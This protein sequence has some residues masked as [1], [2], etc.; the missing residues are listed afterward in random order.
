MAEPRTIY[1][2]T[3]GDYSDYR[4]CGVY[5][6]PAKAKRGQVLHSGRYGHN[7]AIETF[8][9]DDF[10]EIPPGLL[11]WYVRMAR[12]GEAVECVRESVSDNGREWA[13]YGDDETVGFSML[14][15]DEEHAIKIA[16]ERRAGLVAS[17]QWT[18]RH[19]EWRTL[20]GLT[21]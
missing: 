6:T 19:S 15:K 17:G 12:D 9:L 10:G 18:T 4:I 14:A 3:D 1:V 8:T 7:P 2:V 16:N 20:M 21:K 11:P 13:P 5:S